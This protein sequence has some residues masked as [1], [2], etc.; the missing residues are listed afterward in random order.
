[1]CCFITEIIISQFVQHANEMKKQYQ[2]IYFL[3]NYEYTQY[4]KYSWHICG[5]SKVNTLILG[6]N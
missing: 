1:M 3:M 4:E 2:N 5:D 6:Y